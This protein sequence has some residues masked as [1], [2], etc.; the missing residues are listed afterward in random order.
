[1]GLLNLSKTGAALVA[2][3]R[4]AAFTVDRDGAVAHQHAALRFPPALVESSPG[5][6]WPPF[7]ARRGPIAPGRTHIAYP[8]L[9]ITAR[10]MRGGAIIFLSPQT[11]FT[12]SKHN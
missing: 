6:C 11:P 12:P 9:K 1:M 10:E 8:S 7:A 3:C 4:P 5:G 2:A